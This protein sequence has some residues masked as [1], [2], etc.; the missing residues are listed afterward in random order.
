MSLS[1]DIISLFSSMKAIGDDFKED[2][3]FRVP[4][5]S[6]KNQKVI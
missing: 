3:N 6:F 2:G 5:I 4:S 1:G